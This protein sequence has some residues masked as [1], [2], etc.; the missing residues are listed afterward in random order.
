MK[1]FKEIIRVSL[2][3]VASTASYTV[4]TFTDR[5]FLSW[6]SPEAIAASVPAMALSFAVICFFMGTGQYVN[7][8][9]EKG[10]RGQANNAFGHCSV[11]QKMIDVRNDLSETR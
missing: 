1:H 2:P 8:L 9:K 10:K 7:V 5:M 6:Y 3:L 4:L 11:P